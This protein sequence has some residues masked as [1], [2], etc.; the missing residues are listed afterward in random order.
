[1]THPVRTHD[2]PVIAPVPA[3]PTTPVAAG[4]VRTR[5]ARIARVRRAPL[6]QR[7]ARWLAVGASAVALVRGLL[8]LLAAWRAL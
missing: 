7:L 4:R 1:M 6:V 2:S 3:P 8:E 5:L